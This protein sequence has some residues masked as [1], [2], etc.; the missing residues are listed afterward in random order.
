ML[1]TDY[2][3]CIIE[4]TILEITVA[5]LT[6]GSIASYSEMTEKIITDD[7]PE[8]NDKYE[9][10]RLIVASKDTVENGSLD[11]AVKDFFGEDIINLAKSNF[12]LRSTESPPKASIEFNADLFE[13]FENWKKTFSIRHECCH[14]LFHEETSRTLEELIEKYGINY[15]KDIIHCQHEHPVHLHM[16][17]K[18]ASD[19]LKEP[20]GYDGS[21]LNPAIAVYEYRK[22]LGK[23]AAMQFAIQNSVRIM[24]VLELY[25]NIPIQ[26]RYLINHKKLAARK[27]LQSFYGALRVDSTSFPEPRTWLTAKDFLSEEVF[28]QKIQK[29]LTLID[30]Q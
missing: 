12:E 27:Y 9:E 25:E 29:L 22:N 14:L 13:N 8:L 28:F 11:K 7:F 2:P 10:I 16:I 24:S 21:L 26:H 1:S 6:T 18:W 23:K 4:D 17:Q 15:L 20:L 19:W 3:L 30:S 5:N